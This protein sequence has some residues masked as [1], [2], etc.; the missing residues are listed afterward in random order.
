MKIYIYL[1]VYKFSSYVCVYIIFK[2][3]FLDFEILTTLRAGLN[4]PV[5][6]KFQTIKISTLV[7]KK[8]K[9]HLDQSGS[10][11]DF[12]FLIFVFDWLVKTGP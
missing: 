9:K 3:H 6:I 12:D 10:N 1:Q 5:E 11:F 2:V 4:E 7:A 8:R